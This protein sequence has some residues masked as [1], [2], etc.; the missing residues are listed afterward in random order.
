MGCFVATALSLRK[1]SQKKG[2]EVVRRLSAR[3]R[4]PPPRRGVFFAC[5][6]RCWELVAAQQQAY[7]EASA[8]LS[9]RFSVTVTVRASSIGSS[10][11]PLGPTSSLV[12][13]RIR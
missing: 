1:K 3:L 5:L 11:L 6:E 10:Q 4:R 9:S 2:P 12:F 7:L 13:K 8:L